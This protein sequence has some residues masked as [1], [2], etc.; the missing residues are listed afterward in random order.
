MSNLN[1]LRVVEPSQTLLINEQSRLAEKS[2]RKI[3]KLGFG[4]SP[5]RPLD[6]V[7]DALKNNAQ[8]HG[9]I[10]VKGL[11]Q[12]CEAATKFH[13]EIQ[14]LSFKAENCL[15]APGSKM[16][17][18]SI[19]A[20][21]HDADVLIPAPAWVSYEPQASLLGHNVIRVETS[22]ELNWRVDTKT[23]NEALSKTRENVQKI[24][25][26]NYPGNPEG[27]TYNTKQLKELAEVLR[28]HKVLVIADEIYSLLT[29]DATFNSLANF[30]PEGTII[31]TGLSKWS[32]AGGWRLGLAFLPDEMQDLRNV[33]LGVASETYSCAPGPVQYAAVEAYKN[34]ET[35][36][37]YLKNQ[38]TI[39]SILA[40]KSHSALSDAGINVHEGEGGFYLYVDFTPFK[41]PLNSQGIT[42]SEE[43]CVHILKETGVALLHSEVFG[44]P[45]EY[46]SARL[47]YVDFD[48]TKALK[49]A[50]NEEINQE[51]V[52]K[53]CAHTLEGIRGMANWFKSGVQVNKAA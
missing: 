32:G 31:T 23:L 46:F 53:Y 6:R 7:I 24:M 26:L 35:T 41:E 52:E 4:Q 11:P 43:L 17:L 22:F 50:E 19:M 20:S 48:G 21:F 2:G 42:T 1:S 10:P 51:F 29:H 14:G 15:V 47:A 16:H 5:F 49:A 39:L 45:A 36:N 8:E 38:R 40:K 37:T 30:Y 3:Y 44:I 9:Y 28:K 34:D 12:L 27:L 13:N 25:I 33:M 18:Y